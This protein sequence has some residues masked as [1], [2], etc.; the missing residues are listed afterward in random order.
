MKLRLLCV[1]RA[2][3]PWLR[4]G[5]EEYAG[6]IQ[7]YLPLTTVEIKEETGGKKGDSRYIRE[8]EGALLLEKISPAACAIVLD[9][10]GDRL[11]SEEISALIGRHMLDGTAEIVLVI[12]G[13][14]GLSDA[15]RQ[16]ADRI[17]SLSALTLTHLMARLLLLEQIYRGLTILRNEPYHN[18]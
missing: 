1:G 16:R 14:Y 13:A 2:S 11:A 10:R 17:L 15:V 6:R 9:E 4:Q 3:V 12:G 7:R 5:I 8:R 18:R